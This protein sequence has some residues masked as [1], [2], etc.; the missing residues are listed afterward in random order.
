[1]SRLQYRPGAGTDEAVRSSW[2]GRPLGLALEA[3]GGCAYD[4]GAFRYFLEVERARVGRGRRVARLLL[5]RLAPAEETA[6]PHAPASPD[7]LLI[8][9]RHVVR[10]TDIVGWYKEGIVAGAIL[11]DKVEAGEGSAAAGL[12][13]I[14]QAVLLVLPGEWGAR[15]RLRSAA[16]TAR[17]KKDRRS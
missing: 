14:R 15:V 1:M 12:R 4:A 8:G 17:R 11:S 13:R 5:V 6:V 16:I 7:Q 2:R 10:D 9:L 3:H